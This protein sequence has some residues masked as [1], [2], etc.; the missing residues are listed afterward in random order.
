MFLHDSIT[1]F[2]T[3][4]IITFVTR[5]MLRSLITL[6]FGVLFWNYCKSRVATLLVRR[7][8]TISCGNLQQES[9]A[10][11]GLNFLS[12]CKLL[13]FWS[14]IL[15]EK[16]ATLDSW[17]AYG[18]QVEIHVEITERMKMT[19]GETSTYKPTTSL[20]VF[21]CCLTHFLW[22]NCKTLLHLLLVDGRKQGDL[23]S[24]SSG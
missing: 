18:W 6:I 3:L 24:V 17:F 20:S 22:E 5:N 2:A 1:P 9:T 8:V 21:N 15:W 12:N 14:R 4:L 16:R 7:S 10:L 23:K 19:T 13:D 11:I